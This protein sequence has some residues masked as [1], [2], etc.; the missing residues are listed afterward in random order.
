MNTNLDK[1]V[2]LTPDVTWLVDE[3]QGYKML[4][5]TKVTLHMYFPLTLAYNYI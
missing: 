3:W 4:K 1:K 5:I 2:L